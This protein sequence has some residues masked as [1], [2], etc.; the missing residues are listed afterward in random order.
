MSTTL[1]DLDRRYFDAWHNQD[2]DAIAAVLPK[3][4]PTL[5]PHCLN[6]WWAAQQLPS[7]L[8]QCGQSCPTS[9][10]TWSAGMLPRMA[11]SSMNGFTAELTQV[12]IQMVHLQRSALPNA[13][14]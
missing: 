2:A 1:L 4:V 8:K 9:S 14:E 10:W 11:L 13:L 12:A 6:P 5:T 3:I 7:G